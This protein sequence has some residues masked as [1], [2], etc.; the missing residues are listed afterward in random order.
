MAY[1][2][3]NSSCAYIIHDLPCQNL[4]FPSNILVLAS[5]WCEPWWWNIFST[6]YYRSNCYWWLLLSSHHFVTLYIIFQVRKFSAAN[7][8]FDKPVTE[9]NLGEF[10]WENVV[11]ECKDKMPH[12]MR[13]VS[14]AL[15]SPKKIVNQK[16]KG[17]KGQK[18]YGFLKIWVDNCFSILWWRH[19]METFS[20]LLPLCTGN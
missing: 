20:A 9:E 17:R 3:G 6:L 11:C 4:P 1:S 12:T 14:A 8:V 18:R 10:S 16:I 7:S 15:P 5:V 19:P 2:I 13:L